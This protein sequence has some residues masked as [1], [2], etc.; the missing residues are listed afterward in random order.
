MADL[1]WVMLAPTC[2]KSP[3]VI[4]QHHAA[5]LLYLIIPYRF[6]EETGW[7]MGACLCVE[8]NTWLLIA[9]RV[10]NKQGECVGVLYE[11]VCGDFFAYTI[12]YPMF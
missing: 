6:P 7:L 12:N 9:R 8:V 10:F 5:T 2:V 11:A 4:I 3:G 1:I